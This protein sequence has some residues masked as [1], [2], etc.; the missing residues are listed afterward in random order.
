MKHEWK[1]LTPGSGPLVTTTNLGS[2]SR[3]VIGWGLSC[4]ACS[5]HLDIPYD[6]LDTENVATFCVEQGKRDD[7]PGKKT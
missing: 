3:Y 6:E 5:E 4:K 2:P 7:C 1:I